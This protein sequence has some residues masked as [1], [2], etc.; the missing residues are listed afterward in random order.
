M[1]DCDFILNKRMCP[2]EKT[3]DV[4]FKTPLAAD[5]RREF[6]NI[7]FLGKQRPG[8]DGMIALPLLHHKFRENN[9][10]F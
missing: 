1:T 8:V 2:I 7:E 4:G 6:K 10:V 9:C 5:S 3:A